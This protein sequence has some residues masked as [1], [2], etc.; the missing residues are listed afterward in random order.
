MPFATVKSNPWKKGF[1]IPRPRI[2]HLW[3]SAQ[4]KRLVEAAK[5]ETRPKRGEYL[6][7]ELCCDLIREFNQTLKE[8]T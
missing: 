4:W 6:I 1:R 5:G 3:S 7:S 8:T 2:H